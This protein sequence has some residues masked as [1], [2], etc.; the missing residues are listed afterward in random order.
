MKTFRKFVESYQLNEAEYNKE[1]WDSKSDSFKK[2]YLERHPNSIYA[3]K[4]RLTP[5]QKKDVTKFVDKAF[6][7]NS[8][9]AETTRNNLSEKPKSTKNPLLK[10]KNQTQ[11]YNALKSLFNDK[12]FNM[13]PDEYEYMKA[14]GK[15]SSSSWAP[16]RPVNDYQI[17]LVYLKSNKADPKHIHNILNNRLSGVKEWGIGSLGSTEARDLLYIYKNPNTDP[18]DKKTIEKVLAKTEKYYKQHPED[19]QA[20]NFIKWMKT[21]KIDRNLSPFTLLDKKYSDA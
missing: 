19:W 18:N 10:A 8:K 11:E 21:G 7:K 15:K 12:S 1:W 16:N 2:R 13:S 20:E 3:Q 6:G 17:D 4:A 14:N 9:P 5:K